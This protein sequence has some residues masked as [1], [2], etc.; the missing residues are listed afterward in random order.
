[1]VLEE[2]IV[3]LSKGLEVSVLQCVQVTE[4]LTKITQEASTRIN[5]DG[6]LYVHLSAK[7]VKQ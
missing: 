5:L 7:T 3:K 6:W 4:S 2:E 1:M